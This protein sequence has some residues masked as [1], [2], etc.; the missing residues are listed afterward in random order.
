MLGLL[1]VVLGLPVALAILD[2]L[3]LKWGVESAAWDRQSNRRLLWW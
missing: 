2:V 3:A 1:I